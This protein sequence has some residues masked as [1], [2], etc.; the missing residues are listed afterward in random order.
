MKGAMKD[1]KGVIFEENFNER[2]THHN[3]KFPQVPRFP[4][5]CMHGIQKN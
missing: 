3:R 1:F 2:Y 5:S 4:A